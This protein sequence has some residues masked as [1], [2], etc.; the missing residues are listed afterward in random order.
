MSELRI[1]QT[2]SEVPQFHKLKKENVPSHDGYVFVA[3]IGFCF[4]FGYV[5]AGLD[6]LQL[7]AF[8]CLMS[9]LLMLLYIAVITWIYHDLAQLVAVETTTETFEPVEVPQLTVN[10]SNQTRQI[11]AVRA[12]YKLTNGYTLK[13]RQIDSLGVYQAQGHDSVSQERL[14]NSDFWQ[15]GNVSDK[16][17]WYL[18]MRVGLVGEGLLEQRGNHYVW[19]EKGK[20]WLFAS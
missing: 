3:S 10:T 1:V 4:G 11:D 6:G 7:F 18:T 15:S 20:Q 14:V 5:F 2:T 12:D 13:G 9:G 8:V 19:T 16:R 17:K